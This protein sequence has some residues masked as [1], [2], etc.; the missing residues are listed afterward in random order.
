M[1]GSP[2]VSF[3]I[4]CYNYGCY[5]PDCL[6]GIFGQQGGYENFEIIAIDD[7]STDNTREVLGGHCDPRLRVFH[8]EV[9][10]GHIFTVNEGFSLVRGRFIARL[11]PDDRYRPNFL[12]TLLP[13]FEGGPEV[14]LVYGDAAI[15]N[16]QGQVTVPRCDR[17]HGGR[18]VVGNDLIGLLKHNY[19]CAAHCYRSSRSLAVGAARLGRTGVQ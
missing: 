6:A 14:G 9:N 7:C 19:L 5:L 12:G 1:N 16:E 15:I 4:P 18:D 13:K 17:V 2:L 8:H 3:V 10:R 11:D